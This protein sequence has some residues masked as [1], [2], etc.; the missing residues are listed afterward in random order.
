M[1]CVVIGGGPG[2]YVAAIC[3]AKKGASVTL[4][5]KDLMGGTCLNRGCI[6]TK[7]IL[8]SAH[9]YHHVQKSFPGIGVTAQNVTLDFGAVMRSKDKVVTKLRGGVEYLLKKNGVKVIRGEASFTDPR[10]VSVKT[11]DGDVK[12]SADA[13]II[14]TGTSP[15]GLPFARFDGSRILSS[16]HLL[17]MEELPASLAIIGGGV[18]GCE[19]AQAFARFGVKVSIVEMLPRLIATMDPEQSALMARVLKREKV[20][21]YLEHSVTGVEAAQAGVRL[22][23][24]DP[25][26]AENA[27]EAE[28]LLVAVGRS[29]NTS[30]L[31]LEKAG[32]SVSAKGFIEADE[33]MR[34]GAPGIFAIG[35]V[36]GVMQLAH[37]ASHQGMVAVTNMLGGDEEMSYDAVPQCVYTEPEI[38]SIG[39]TE[40]SAAPQS[41]KAGMFPASANGRS[42]IEGISD[43]FSKVIVDES[44]R[45]VLGV[46]LAGP[47]V[48]EMISHMSGVIQWETTLDDMHPWIYAHP[49]VSEM[50]HESM[51]DVEGLAIHF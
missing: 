26:G 46:H 36:T 38:A 28:K 16:D 4:I 10:N 6:P 43:G 40:A 39:K 29:P 23:F 22:L 20:D 11:T 49:S 15:A 31:G 9:A 30:A 18:I 14:A 27:I 2:G 35:D 5:E 32:V 19:F 42:M 12:V 13:F 51:L 1:E 41:V 44:S 45:T 17:Q 37:I 34:T 8:H 33:G 24:K 3:A 48:T 21:L 47:N 7:A 50:V 25:A